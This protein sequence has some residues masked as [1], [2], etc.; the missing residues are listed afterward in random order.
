MFDV[1]PDSGAKIAIKL[2]NHVQIL[3]HLDDK[4]LSTAPR[5]I[6]MNVEGMSLYYDILSP[7]FLDLNFLMTI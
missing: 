5:K 3:H 2:G 1:H 6:E 7:K 4:F